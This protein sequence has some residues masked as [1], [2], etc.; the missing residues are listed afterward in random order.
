MTTEQELAERY[1]RGRRRPLPWIVIGI[2]AAAL[3]GGL[4]WM[5]VANSLT[6]VSTTDRGFAVTDAHSVTVHY[7]ISAP[8]G[9]DVICYVQALDEEFGIVGWKVVEIA[10]SADHTQAFT[11]VVPT[12]AEATTGLVNSCRVS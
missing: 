11:T 8:R 2:A 7:Q 9:R 3:I 1:G 12:V 4:A 5:T 10:A 6:Q